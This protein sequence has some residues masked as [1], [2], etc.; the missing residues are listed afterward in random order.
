[1]MVSEGEGSVGSNTDRRFRPE[2]NENIHL[3]L[4]KER[5]CLHS[6]GDVRSAF[7][8]SHSESKSTLDDSRVDCPNLVLISSE[9]M[10]R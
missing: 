7:I 1:M 5:M 8:K 2:N 9:S 3:H 10:L 6:I 4:T